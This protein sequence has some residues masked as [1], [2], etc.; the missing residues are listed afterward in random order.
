MLKVLYISISWLKNRDVSIFWNLWVL[1]GYCVYHFPSWEKQSELST[2]I[3]C[4]VCGG[5][6]EN[7]QIRFPWFSFREMHVG[8]QC[9]SP[10]SQCLWLFKTS[11]LSRTRM[12]DLSCWTQRGMGCLQVGMLGIYPFMAAGQLLCWCFGDF[13]DTFSRTFLRK[14]ILHFLIQ[15]ILAVSCLCCKNKSFS[16]YHY[17]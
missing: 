3:L 16:I 4:Q 11:F 9:V 8:W 14:E 13:S 6:L 12:L 1:K 7:I 2:Q 15:Q 10:C 5:A 17:W